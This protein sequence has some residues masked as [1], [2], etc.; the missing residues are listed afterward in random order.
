[1][2]VLVVLGVVAVVYLQARLWLSDVGVIESRALA[3]RV[4]EQRARNAALEKRNAE[5][6]SEVQALKSGLDAVEARARTE[7]GMIKTGET[8]YLVV[9]S[10][11]DESDRPLPADSARST[12]ARDD[13]LPRSRDDALP[14]PAQ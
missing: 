12:G 11:D 8:F 10:R 9:D 5:L 4:D 3:A 1:M 2:R 7:L 6:A 14:R 13:A